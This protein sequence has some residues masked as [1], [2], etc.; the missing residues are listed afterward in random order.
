ML[1]YYNLLATNLFT[2]YIFLRL[3]GFLQKKI[4]IV[5]TI[6]LLALNLVSVTSNNETIYYFILGVTN[7]F[8]FSSFLFLLFIILS[9]FI[10]NKTTIFSY[11]SLAFLPIIIVFYG[12]FFVLSYKLYDFGYKP[13]IVVP[14]IFIYALVLLSI[15]KKFVLFNIIIVISSAIFFTNILQTNI[16][17]YLL[18]PTL[19]II[20]IIEIITCMIH[21][22]KKD[23]IIKYY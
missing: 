10:N 19:L 18:D 16:W 6:I 23:K 8:S 13:Y 4:L 9:I 15:S 21:L 12:L 1:N 17:N 2:I 11:T 5:I 7:Y 22:K 20:C 3:F 14:F